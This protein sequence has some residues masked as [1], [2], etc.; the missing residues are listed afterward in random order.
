MTGK[1]SGAITRI[2]NVAKNSS[3][4]HCILHTYALV[5]KMIS[6]SLKTA[7]D[8]AVQIINFSKTRPLQSRIFKA[9]CEDMGSHHTTL[10]LHTEVRW[11]SRGNVIVRMVEL[12]KELLFYFLDHKFRLSDRLRNSIWLSKVAYLVDFFLFKIE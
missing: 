1:L 10:L 11:L 5:T 9:L 2:K 3:S 8:E 12:K 4:D 6:A 7:L